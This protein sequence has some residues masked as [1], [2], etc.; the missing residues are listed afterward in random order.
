[1]CEMHPR[2]CLF[3][4]L[5]YCIGLYALYANCL[6]EGFWSMCRKFYRK[7]GVSLMQIF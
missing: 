4:E 6:G 3:T 1:M 7:E 2:A 5:L